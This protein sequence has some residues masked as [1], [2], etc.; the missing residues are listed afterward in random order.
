MLPV[1]K[2]WQ[3]NTEPTAT[4]H[5]LMIAGVIPPSLNQGVA[6]AAENWGDPNAILDSL[7]NDAVKTVKKLPKP[8]PR[9]RQLLREGSPSK[10]STDGS[11]E[12][13]EGADSKRTGTT[14]TLSSGFQGVENQAPQDGAG[15]D[16]DPDAYEYYM[17]DPGDDA[18][19]YYEDRADVPEE[20]QEVLEEVLRLR[21]Q[22]CVMR[23]FNHVLQ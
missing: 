12:L 6:V 23:E 9:N 21:E 1:I 15:A 22:V 14:G 13:V 17:D 19:G 3:G 5:V 10:H 4:T 18:Q 11:W 20:Q 8:P 7:L 16:D 2:Y